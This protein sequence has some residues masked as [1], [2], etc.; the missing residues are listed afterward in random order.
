MTCQSCVKS[1]TSALT[2]LEGVATVSVS[3]P[4]CSATVNYDPSLITESQLTETIEDCGFDTTPTEQDSAPLLKS[5]PDELVQLTSLP[6]M[7]IAETK[8]KDKKK[9]TEMAHTTLSVRGMTCASCVANIEKMVSPATLPGL[10]S[11]R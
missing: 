10:I 6:P 2:S 5:T 8:S 11:D 4:N 1:V 7:S 9:V 3:L